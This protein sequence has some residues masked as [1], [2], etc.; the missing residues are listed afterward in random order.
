LR[1]FY[2][3]YDYEEYSVKLAV[4]KHAKDYASIMTRPNNTKPVKTP[5]IP[6]IKPS[7]IEPKIKTYT[8]FYDKV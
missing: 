1:S 6:G 8:D 4:N 2:Q 3:V 5:V 7:I